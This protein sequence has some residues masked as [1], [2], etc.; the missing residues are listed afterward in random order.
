MTMKVYKNRDL[1]LK[2]CLSAMCMALAFALPFVTGYIPEIGNALSPMHLPAFLFGIVA[3][4]FFGG[5]LAFLAPVL[6]SLMFGAPAP[7]FPRAITMS[8][9]L[10]A[11]ALVFGLLY[12]LLSK[13]LPYIYVSLVSAMIV[14]RLVGGIVKIVLL[15][16]GVIAK[17]NLALFI[18]GYVTESIPGIVVQLLVIPP[19]VLALRRAKLID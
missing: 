5:A 1:T 19:V 16:L 13:K 14:G 10:M 18:S 4:P 3:G 8:F 15:K 12:K 2:I 11:Y 17:Y 6:R 9:E 7:L